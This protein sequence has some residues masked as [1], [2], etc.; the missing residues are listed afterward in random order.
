MF[1]HL[2]L[3]QSLAGTFLL[4]KQKLHAFDPVNIILSFSISSFLH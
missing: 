4:F 1:F 3:C 2:A